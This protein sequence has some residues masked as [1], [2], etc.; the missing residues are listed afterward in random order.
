MRLK[1]FV[2]CSVPSASVSRFATPSGNAVADGGIPYIT[3][4]THVP[5]G[6]SGS[7]HTSARLLAWDGTPDHASGGET[8]S[9]L[10]VWRAGIAWPASNTVLVTWI[11]MDV[12]SPAGTPD[13]P[14]DRTHAD[15][16]NATSGERK[17]RTDLMW[18]SISP[19]Q[20]RAPVG[21]HGGGVP[22]RQE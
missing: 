20:R 13:S 1:S 6:A 17:T 7:S 12:F 21:G 18:G 14:P 5:A 22:A 3:Q 9:P 11:V 16:S 8:S 4:C 15:A 19:P 10:Q 2:P